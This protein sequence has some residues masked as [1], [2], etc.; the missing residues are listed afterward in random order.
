MG[1]ML[2]KGARGDE[3]KAL[4]EQ[5]NRFGYGLTP[6][7]I[8]GDGT[9]SAVR[10]LQKSFGYTVDGTV[11]DGTRALIAQQINYNWNKNNAT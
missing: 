5:L 4:Q 6:D 9:E 8:F 3:V 10:H 1:T 11:G 2:K 7:G